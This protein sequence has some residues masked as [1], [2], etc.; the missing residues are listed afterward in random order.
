M[1]A[2][3]ASNVDLVTPFTRLLSVL[4]LSAVNFERV[5]KTRHF[6]RDGVPARSGSKHKKN[7]A[8][9]FMGYIS[10]LGGL[11]S[12]CHGRLGQGDTIE[13]EKEDEFDDSVHR[14]I[15]L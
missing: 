14:I 8:S 3:Y 13:V 5:N 7:G 1:R 12:D 11:V 15:C 2:K 6:A 9:Q 10:N 4:S